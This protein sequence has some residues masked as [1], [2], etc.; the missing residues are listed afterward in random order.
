MGT[1][2][3]MSPEQVEGKPL[4]CRTDIYS[5]RRHLLLH[6]GRPTA[7]RRRHRL[8]GG[9]E[10]RPRRA[11][12]AGF[13][14]AGPAAGPVRRR[15]Q[16]DGQGSRRTVIRPARNSSATW[17]RFGRGLAARPW[18]SVGPGLSS[19]AAPSSAGLPA[20]ARPRPA[21]PA[22]S[23][24]VDCTPLSEGAGSCPGRRR[25]PRL[26][27]ADRRRR[28]PGRRTSPPP[29]PPTDDDLLP[30]NDE[31]A[32]RK[33]VDK[34]LQPSGAGR[35]VSVG[36]GLCLD[37]GMLYLEQHRLDE[38][39]KLFERL[40]KAPKPGNTSRSAGWAAPW[41][42]P[43]A[44]RRRSPISVSGNSRQGPTAPGHRQALEGRQADGPGNRKM[45]TNPQFRFWLAQA[46]NHNLRNGVPKRTCR[47]PFSAGASRLGRRADTRPR[48]SVSCGLAGE[49]LHPTRRPSSRSRL[50]FRVANPPPPSAVRTRASRV[51]SVG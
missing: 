51:L 6:A 32:L 36:M 45:W 43:S 16:D 47:R 14:P 13:R 10:A 42:W 15:P 18:R 26:A 5:L 48:S 3:Y 9:H 49:P 50:A 33:L 2:L 12:A 29:T 35:N 8:R 21:R 41:C 23:P 17:P 46:V 37:L 22:S 20:A 34:Y 4:D 25:R 11:A 28:G 39:D 30:V 44:M 1:P 24:H 31:E 7:L 40:A 38:A 19:R 27:A